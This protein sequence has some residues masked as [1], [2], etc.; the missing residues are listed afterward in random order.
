[1]TRSWRLPV[2]AAAWFVL[3]GAATAAAQTVV[4]R[5][6]P[7]GS[8]VEV[9]FGPAAG[10]GTVDAAGNGTVELG[11]TPAD[12][13]EVPAAIHVEA[14]GTTT[15]VVIVGRTDETPPPAPGCQRRQATG[16]FVMRG[17]TSL[18]IDVEPSVPTVRIRQGPVPP[19]WMTDEVIVTGR[20]TPRGIVVFGGGGL[21]RM[22]NEL[23]R[24]CGNALT[25]SRESTK[26]G[27]TGGAAYWLTRWLGAEASFIKPRPFVV[28]GFDE[29]YEFSSRINPRIAQVSAVG[30][31]SFGATR[32][33]GRLGGA[34][35]RAEVRTNQITYG[36]TIDVGD[37]V[38]TFPGD[39]QRFV[40]ETVGWGRIWGFGVEG[41]TG[42]RTALFAD[43]SFIQIKG[44]NADEDG[45]VRT[46][47]ER[48][49]VINAGLKI[50]FGFR[51]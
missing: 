40:F 35:H 11:E 23:L 24:L 19:A 49:F 36:R 20:T 2:W 6:A 1:M 18:V 44:E 31:W 7:A 28:E 39:E 15:R 50:H 25:C 10:K 29:S 26:I 27:F 43:V 34:Y 38:E 30:G 8:S 33:Y 21:G 14:C 13:A 37:T 3:A 45:G 46:L 17:E 51:R 41:W 47:D 5:H 48:P 4:V 16:Y 9:A 42:E 12:Q 22:P 32:F